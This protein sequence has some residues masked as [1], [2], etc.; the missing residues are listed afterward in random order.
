MLW[1]GLNYMREH[2]GGTGEPGGRGIRKG[3]MEEVPLR[4]AQEGLLSFEEE[5]VLS[6]FKVS[7]GRGPETSA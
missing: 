1:E 6:G 5:G 7:D 3:F 4:Q 2:R